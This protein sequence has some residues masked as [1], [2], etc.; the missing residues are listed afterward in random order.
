MSAVRQATAALPFLVFVFSFCCLPASSSVTTSC[1]AQDV[2]NNRKP[3]LEER[4]LYGLKVRTKDERVFI[5]LVVKLV[6]TGKI[7]QEIVDQA[8]FWV[9]K[10]RE[11]KKKGDP[12]AKKHIEKYPFFYF[13]E[14]FKLNAKRAGVVIR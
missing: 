5:K 12:E 10:E 9:Q 14:V 4:L 3:T 8:F 2:I 6:E 1:S 7:K 13:K 11:R